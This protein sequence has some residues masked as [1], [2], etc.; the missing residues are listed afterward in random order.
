M[1]DVVNSKCGDG[2]RQPPIPRYPSGTMCAQVGV[3]SLASLQQADAPWKRLAPL[4][5]APASCPTSLREKIIW[6]GAASAY[7][8]E[9]AW[10]ADGKGPSIW[11]T[12]TQ[13]GGETQGNATGDVAN[14]HYHSFSVAWSRI[15]PSGV[16]GSPV[17]AAGV[18]W[19][20][21]LVEALLG[22]GIVPAITMYHW[23]LPQG[24]QDSS[25]G[26]LAE[27]AAFQDAFVYYADT[28]FRELGPLV[29]LW[30]TFNEP[31]SIC[32]LGF[33]AGVFAP[34]IKLGPAG[35]YRCGRNLLLAHAR[36]VK[37]YRQKYRAAQGGRIA[38]ALD[39]KWGWP[40]DAKSEAD[41]KAAQYWMEFQY[42]WMADPVYFG[43]YPASMLQHLNASL[44]PRFTREEGV[45][46]K[47]TLDFFAVNFYCGYF[48]QARQPDAE[49]PYPYTV[50]HKNASGQWVGTPTVSSWLFVTP[51]ALRE[52]LVWLDRRYSVGG[53]KVEFSISENGVSGPAEDKLRPP[54]VLEDTFR[55]SYYT[56]YLT[57]LCRAIQEDG[58]KFTTYWAWSLWDNFEW[59][60]AY[61]QRFGMIYVDLKNNLTRTPK[62]SAWWFAKHFYSGSAR[63]D[64]S[65]YHGLWPGAK[66]LKAGR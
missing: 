30:M 62:A 25:G 24:L 39:G 7:Q 26:F 34:G 46:L 17:N 53:R 45:L 51:T 8:I 57:S 41:K 47:G 10:N 63:H 22:A 49:S 33:S 12:F 61:T 19:Y 31:L 14:D 48:I 50:L 32:E 37:L 5:P 38:M 23:D 59:R 11:D 40:Y 54:A 43:D 20:R 42:G 58:V 55:L 15:V 27:G 65:H 64:A 9:G 16:A 13:K 44:L 36:A 35:Q 56:G 4:P 3:C 18:R 6:G 2:L 1:L 60:E 28:L 66:A 29:K 52:T 21:E